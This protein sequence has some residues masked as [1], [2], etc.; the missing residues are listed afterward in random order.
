MLPLAWS[1][2]VALYH[3]YADWSSDVFNDFIDINNFPSQLLIIHGFLLDYV[4]G[5]LCLPVTLPNNSPG[6]KG[7]VIGWARDVLARLPPDLKEYGAW[8]KEYSDALEHGDW[9]Y[10]LSP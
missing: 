9:R 4:L 8:V 2:F 6:R 7:V 3:V 5:P 10:L 1:A